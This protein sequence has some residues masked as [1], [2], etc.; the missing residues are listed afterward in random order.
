MTKSNS[1]GTTKNTTISTRNSRGRTSTSTS[2]TTITSSRNKKGGTHGKGGGG[3]RRRSDALRDIS[4]SH[5]NPNP[6]TNGELKFITS[7]NAVNSINKGMIHVREKEEEND[8]DIDG[9]HDSSEFY[10]YTNVDDD[11]DHVD[12]SEGVVAEGV[13]DH[14]HHDDD[15]L[16]SDLV[17]HD[18]NDGDD[19]KSSSSSLSLSQSATTS[20]IKVISGYMIISYIFSF[21]FDA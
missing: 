17:S 16:S 19:D 7:S 2:K 14:N 11:L 18:T 5:S 21:L 10:P 8:D 12:Y 15:N 3:A 9:S 1:S 4:N 6:A 20:R 13:E